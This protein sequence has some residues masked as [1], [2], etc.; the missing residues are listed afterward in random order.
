VSDIDGP[1]E[2]DDDVDASIVIALGRIDA[3]PAPTSVRAAVL[4]AASDEPRPGMVPMPPLEVLAVCID[5]LDDVLSGLDDDDWLQRAAPYDWS[6]AQLVAH[7]AAVDRY[8]SAVLGLAPRTDDPDHRD[9][10]A[11]GSAYRTSLLRGTTRELHRA[12]RATAMETLA[13]LRAGDGPA[14][15][16]VV[17]FHVWPFTLDTLL[18]AR[19]FELWTHA[20]DIRRAVGRPVASPPPSALRCMSAASV[21]SLP[22]LVPAVAA[23]RVVGGARVVLTGPGG[24]TFDIGIG[25]RAV[26][27]VADV[28]DYCRVV[29]RRAGASAIEVDGDVALAA[30]LV[31]AAQAIAM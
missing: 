21:Q 12:W 31:A 26:T 9:H 18:V 29:A 4:R 1:F 27:L 11:V 30:D 19:S 2:R 23:R 24:G 7:V 3:E 6:V 20:D 22:L 8:M 13:R 14:A 17:E 28:V 16:D 5:D 10:L 15:D 25:Q